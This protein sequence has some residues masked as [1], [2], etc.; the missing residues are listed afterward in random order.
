MKKFTCFIKNGLNPQT[1]FARNRRNA[2]TLYRDL[3]AH[4]EKFS[5]V[6]CHAN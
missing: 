4:L 3:Y 1:I 6:Y 5:D 2:K